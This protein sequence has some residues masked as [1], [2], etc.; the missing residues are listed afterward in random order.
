M[1]ITKT[2]RKIFDQSSIPRPNVRY[3]AQPA[4]TNIGNLYLLLKREIL[5]LAKS[6]LKNCGVSFASTNPPSTPHRAQIR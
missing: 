3:R 4:P 6:S 5:D 2:P 1:V